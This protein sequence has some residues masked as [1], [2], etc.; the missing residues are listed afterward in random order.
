[1]AQNQVGLCQA[2]VQNVGVTLQVVL[3][4]WN[5]LRMYGTDWGIE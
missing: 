2:D 4:N 3:Y 1:M 5:G